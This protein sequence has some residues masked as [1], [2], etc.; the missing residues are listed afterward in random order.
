MSSAQTYRS[1]GHHAFPSGNL[2][3]V[4]GSPISPR[5]I[6]TT[7]NQQ[8]CQ[9]S[10]WSLTLRHRLHVGKFFEKLRRAKGHVGAGLLHAHLARTHARTHARTRAH[11][12]THTFSQ[13]H[14][15]THAH[16][17]THMHTHKHTNPQRHVTHCDSTTTALTERSIVHKSTGRAHGHNDIIE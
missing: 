12:H 4:C 1:C 2:G 10:L 16:A 11:S 5:A 14:T 3:V 15:L 6:S 13:A 7:K 8:R 9:L 17:N